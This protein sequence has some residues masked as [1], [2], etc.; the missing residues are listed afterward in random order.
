MRIARAEHGPMTALVAT[1]FAYVESD[2]PADMTLAAWRA[3]RR[4]TV[5]RRRRRRRGLRALLTRRG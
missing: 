1:S 2:V 4:A 5:K 3:S